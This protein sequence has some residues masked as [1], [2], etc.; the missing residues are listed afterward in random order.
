MLCLNCDSEGHQFKNCRQPVRSYGIIS[1]K[2]T[3]KGPMYLLIQRKDTIGKTDFIRGKYKTKGRIDFDNLSCLINEMTDKE[4]QEVLDTDKEL[5][6]KKLWLDHNTGLFK[7]GKAKAM[8]M[9][10]EIDYREILSCSSPSRY[11]DNEWGFPKGRKNLF[12]DAIQCSIREFQEETGLKRRDFVVNPDITFNE[13]FTASDGRRYLHVY[14]LA[15][16]SPEVEVTID[17]KNLLFTQEVKDI[18][19]FDFIKSYR[20]FRDYDVQKKHVLYRVNKLL[21]S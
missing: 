8:K 13:E 17:L 20:L 3:D 19:F 21:S 9:F 7:N 4:K 1:Y 10:D 2:Q 18:G 6:W 12:E 15:K 14:F 11:D 16:I 5:L